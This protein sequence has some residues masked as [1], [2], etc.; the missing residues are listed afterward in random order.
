MWYARIIYLLGLGF[1]IFLLFGVGGNAAFVSFILLLIYIAA[2]LVSILLS[3]AN[4]GK[5]T[6]KLKSPSGLQQGQTGRIKLMGENV[7]WLAVP[8]VVAKLT[9]SDY[10]T[11]TSVDYDAKF[12]IAG[13][14]KNTAEVRM[15]DAEIG[16][17]DVVVN[18]LYITDAFHLARFHLPAN[19]HGSFLVEPP[20][21]P[22][23]IVMGEATEIEGSSQKYSEFNP[24]HDVSETFD[25]RSYAVGDSVRSIHWKLSSKF[26]DLIVREYGKPV[27]FSLVLLAELAESSAT[28]LESCVAYMVGI[29]RR[30]LAHGLLHTIAWYDAGAGE[31][32][33]YNI[34]DYEQLE[35]AVL[36]LIVSCP[37]DG[38]GESL[39]R[40][41][42]DLEPSGQ[43]KTLFY[44]TTNFDNNL[45]LEAAERCTARVAIVG[46]RGADTADPALSVDTLPEDS[47]RVSA[48]RLDMEKG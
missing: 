4:R 14:S 15:E 24:G 32:C 21:I 34:T 27:E 26:D 7:S 44:F 39:A 10:L 8:L 19:Q 41:L 5:V 12:P 13:N 43:K 35:A 3:L 25:T 48:L 17:I 2:P 37:H 22:V 36:R 31:Y 18:E 45:M 11:G 23:S 1:L 33:S 6:V 9:V 30:L 38:T 40:F 46:N 16:R 20:K 28:A 29:S 47:R 42:G